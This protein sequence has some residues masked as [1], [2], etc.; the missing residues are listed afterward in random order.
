MSGPLFRIIGLWGRQAWWLAAGLM[1]S[2]AALAAG[3]G[4]MAISGYTIGAG[5][6]AGA[7]GGGLAGGLVGTGGVASGVASG[8]TIG[9]ASGVASAGLALLLLREACGESNGLEQQGP[10]LVAEIILA[11]NREA[12][13][14]AQAN[15]VIVSPEIV[16]M[17]LTQISQQ[18]MLSAIYDDLLTAG[19]MEIYIKPASRYVTLG[20]EVTFGQVIAAAYEVGEIALG[21]RIH[22]EQYDV[23]RNFGVRLNM[24]KNTVLNFAEGD[25]V[26]AMAESLYD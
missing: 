21:V 2:L 19:G 24:D 1:V 15:E 23:N 9:V 26:V 4:L 13:A 20:T 6:L 25:R 3:I 14:S 10:Q 17:I 12:V 8:V 22:A 11:K 7:G 16:A 5:V 18:Q